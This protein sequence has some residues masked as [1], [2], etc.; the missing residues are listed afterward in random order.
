[1]LAKYCRVYNQ[2][3]ASFS[4]FSAKVVIFGC[5]DF[6]HIE[7]RRPVIHFFFSLYTAKAGAP[8]KFKIAKRKPKPNPFNRIKN[9]FSHEN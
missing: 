3:K 1:M 2:P 5:T 9:L 7:K 6:S 4:R 8:L